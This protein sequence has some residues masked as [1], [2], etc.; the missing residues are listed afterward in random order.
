MYKHITIY[1]LFLLLLIACGS[2]ERGRMLAV[3]DEADS[4][5]RNYIPFTTDS[6]LKIAAEWFDSHGSANERVRAH[7]LLGCAYRDMGEGLTMGQN[8]WIYNDNDKLKTMYHESCHYQQIGR[9]GGWLD[10][11]PT[12]TNEYLKYGFEKSYH[13]RTSYEN[14]AEFYTIMKVGGSL[15]D[16]INY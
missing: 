12:I 11:Y 3:L 14:M 13:T 9:Y 16:F 4:L 7:Y 8:M 2:S 5:N 15:E 6:V 10:F 1:T